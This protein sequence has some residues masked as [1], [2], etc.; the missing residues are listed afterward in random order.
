MKRVLAFET[1]QSFARFISQKTS[2]VGF[3]LLGCG[4]VKKNETLATE[5]DTYFFFPELTDKV[6]VQPRKF[7]SN[8]S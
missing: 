6:N 4:F 5:K 8:T 2:V 7:M 3:L 1:F